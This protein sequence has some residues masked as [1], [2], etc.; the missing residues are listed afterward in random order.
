MIIAISLGLIAYV[1]K[2]F[3]KQETLFKQITSGAFIGFLTAAIIG[4]CYRKAWVQYCF[5][6]IAIYGLVASIITLMLISVRMYFAYENISLAIM[7][8]NVQYIFNLLVIALAYLARYFF[9]EKASLQANSF[10]Q[11]LLASGLGSCVLA[12]SSWG[13]ALFMGL[14]P[15]KFNEQMAQAVMPKLEAWQIAEKWWFLIMSLPHILC[16]VM[17]VAIVVWII[18]KLTKIWS[19]QLVYIGSLFLFA[20]LLLGHG[21]QHLTAYIKGRQ[22]SSLIGEYGFITDVFI[23][24]VSFFIAGLLS[25]TKRQS[26]RTD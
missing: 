16:N 4:A 25:T 21:L 13:G 9:D 3:A 23:I 20:S 8:F 2:D 18:S 5:F 17:L 22:V 12:V 1:L 24:I 11:F 14:L 26:A 15:S 19:R 6:A 7:I 10:T